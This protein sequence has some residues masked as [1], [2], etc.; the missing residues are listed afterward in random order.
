MK[1]NICNMDEGFCECCWSCKELARR[2][3]EAKR[4]HNIEAEAFME[5]ATKLTQERDE[6]QLVA[7]TLGNELKFC[8]ESYHKLMYKIDSRSKLLF[9][10][11]S[12]CELYAKDPYDGEE[13][14]QRE[15]F[16][17]AKAIKEARK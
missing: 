10:L 7:C 17:K 5:A 15:S 2:F 6:A 3:D 16:K 12:D 11:V 13:P 8:Q 14:H 1:C 4:A 9:D